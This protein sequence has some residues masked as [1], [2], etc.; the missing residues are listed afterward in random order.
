[1][2]PA[3][4]RPFR[5]LPV[6]LVLLLLPSSVRGQAPVPIPA[7]NINIGG[8]PATLDLTANP[9]IVRGDFLL[10]QQNEPSCTQGSR[11]GRHIFCGAND[12]RLVDLP[13]IDPNSV[14]RDAWPG[15]L[16]STDGGE[17]WES[18]VHPGSFVDPRPSVLKQF[19]AGADPT[20]RGGPGGIVYYSGIAFNRTGNQRGVVF[21]STWMDLVNREDDRMP[22]KHVRTV[23]VDTGNSGQF[24]DKPWMFV[25]EPEG[26][27]TCQIA[28]PRADGA[29]IM[30]SVPASPIYLAY[31]KFVGDQPKPDQI[32][33]KLVVVKSVDCGATWN[34]AVKVSEGEGISQGAA[35]TKAL[36]TGSSRVMLVW[37]RFN[38]GKESDAILGA[39]SN[40]NGNTWSKPLTIAAPICPFQQGTTSTQFR[41][42]A[43]PTITSDHTGRFHVAWADRGK[44]SSGNCLANGAA[45]IVLTSSANGMNWP[46]PAAV[47]DA[48]VTVNGTPERAHQI[49]PAL[50]YAG[51]IVHLLWMDL[52]EDVSRYF[53]RKIDDYPLMRAAAGLPPEANLVPTPVKRHT[54]DAWSKM[55]MPGATLLWG[56]SVKVSQYRFGATSAT[57]GLR[58]LQFNPQNLRLFGRGTKV[59]NGDYLD[60][61]TQ[62]FAPPD[63]AAGRP[64]WTYNT[65]Q[66]GAPVFL[67]AWPDNRDVRRQRR[68][69]DGV[70]PVSY[71]PPNFPGSASIADPTQPRPV[72]SALAPELTGTMNQNVYAARVGQ[73]MSAYAANNTK[74]IGNFARAF[75][76][77]V[78]NDSDEQKGYLLQI[79]TQ[80]ARGFASFTQFS[81][82]TS[83]VLTVPKRS[84]VSQ[85]VYVAPDADPNTPPPDPHAQ[86]R[87]DVTEMGSPLYSSVYLN[88]DPTAPEVE[89]P[90]VEAP[91]VEAQEVY[92]PEVEAAT[93]R[94]LS[95]LNPE[96]E[97][98]EVE[99]VGAQAPE[100]EA[101]EVE[102]PEV[103]AEN[104]LS[105]SAWASSIA[106]PEVEAPEVEAPEVEA[107]SVVDITWPV[108]N[109][110]NTTAA[111][112]LR[113]TVTGGAGQYQFQLIISKVYQIAA[114]LGCEPAHSATQSVA[115][116]IQNANLLVSPGVNI[117]PSSPLNATFT[118]KPGETWLVTLRARGVA[119]LNTPP[120]NPTTTATFVKVQPQA[121][122]TV[123]AAA[124]VVTP[125]AV[126]VGAEPPVIGTTALAAATIGAPYSAQLSASGGVPPYSW[127]LNSGTLAPGL[128]VQPAGTITGTPTT[129]GTFTFTVR[130]VDSATLPQTATRTLTMTVNAQ[131]LKLAFITQPSSSV[132]G[133][134]IPS[135]QVAVQDQNGN[136]ITSPESSVTLAVGTSPT[137]GS[138]W[139]TIT[140]M[141]VDGVATFNDVKVSRSGSG[142]TLTASS[143]GTTS[144]TSQPFKVYGLLLAATDNEEFTSTGNERL[145]RYAMDGT[146]V[147]IDSSVL[148]GYPING[149]TRVGAFLFAG[150][151][152]LNKLRHLDRSGA[153]I[154]T[155]TG[156]F[157]NQCCN[158]DMV[159]DG[160][161]L[162]HAHYGTGQ[163]NRLDPS[164]TTLLASYP[165]PGGPVGMTLVGSDIWT[166]RW[167]TRGVGKW[168]PTGGFALQFTIPA[169]D[170][171][172]GGLAYD[173][174]GGVL[175]VGSRGKI[176]P[177]TTAGVK[178][179]D[180]IVPTS[181]SPNTNT[182]DGLEF[183]WEVAPPQL[184][185][186]QP[187]VDTGA[188]F[189]HVIGTGSDQQLAQV[190]TQDQK[191]A[192]LVGVEAPIGCSSGTSLILEIQG[193]TGGA[194]NGTVLASRVFPGDFANPLGGFR[195]FSFVDPGTPNPAFLSAGMP[196]AIVAR[197]TNTVGNCAWQ[198]GPEGSDPYI[199][200]NALVRSGGGSWT[201][202]SGRPDLPF[203]TKV[204]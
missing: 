122:G 69:D 164:G 132:V 102:A 146:N 166:T 47:D 175:W 116:N 115:V 110:G 104:I 199:G 78:R 9:P 53:D 97:A 181:A 157:P 161:S 8:G 171:V 82:Q 114:A 162:Y 192:F 25:G 67:D 186:E 84:S 156:A 204:Q 187:Q 86:V 117:D 2:T 17:T 16:Q 94:T 148:T 160:T 87:V 1:M 202:F 32:R 30:Q 50:A 96:V 131:I 135:M 168:T 190:I 22:F 7:R 123:D 52:R 138:A 184:G 62:L 72:C 154:R 76:V 130:V 6:L 29:T 83:F 21:V 188:G 182:L 51:G 23:E 126:T 191:S 125:P 49:T 98:P 100:V 147:M 46:A 140:K 34:H 70:A 121:V 176:T 24:L 137:G 63:I 19:H 45:R 105:F 40:D 42:N 56:P 89:A 65:G 167:S 177:Y 81:L 103:E 90:E 141:T 200:G 101:P 173:P 77:T 14:T 38:N 106:T 85:T 74:Q 150:E 127:A 37:R 99:A 93:I 155:T 178:I 152:N 55:A 118:A 12:Y 31:S 153:L 180:A 15:V 174:V 68:A 203:K 139:G 196:F 5:S 185:Q 149:L 113:P 11:N 41:V 189:T 10:K 20:V 108:K 193:V 28:V 197:T 61:A 75:A 144:G 57:G 44:D 142:Y 80:P 39:V 119:G 128:S 120:F 71:T 18:T 13:G 54:A 136:T 92:T 60:I 36:R 151:P 145:Y 133:E 3:H 159:F 4:Q 27:A 170:S 179:G 158:E 183:I 64:N 88:P 73:G 134:P 35:I 95:I 143:P 107:N 109:K 195:G 172:A 169:E 58:Q 165:E 33:T 201:A 79:A 112:N 198:P 26:T 48:V 124:G 59:F 66:L 43:F 129:A 194:P 91:E 163:I 111:Y